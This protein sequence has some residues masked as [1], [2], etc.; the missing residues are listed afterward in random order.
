M[1]DK[2]EEELVKQLEDINFNLSI[3]RSKV[4]ITKAELNSLETDLIGLKLSQEKLIEELRRL[5]AMKDSK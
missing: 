4:K 1:L 3:V 5:R 2:Q